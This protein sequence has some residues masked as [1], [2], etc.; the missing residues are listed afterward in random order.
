[1][2]ERTSPCPPCISPPLKA[3]R[4]QGMHWLANSAARRL[5]LQGHPLQRDGEICKWGYPAQ[6]VSSQWRVIRGFLRSCGSSARNGNQLDR[7]WAVKSH[8]CDG[9][10]VF[11]R[12]QPPR[13]F[14]LEQVG[15][16]ISASPGQ[17]W[18]TSSNLGVFDEEAACDENSM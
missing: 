1:M 5:L 15:A 16:H 6:Q 12:Q 4:S 9:V 8:Y 14:T 13:C 10:V 18:R 11:D 17:Q 7:G 3:H 2:Q